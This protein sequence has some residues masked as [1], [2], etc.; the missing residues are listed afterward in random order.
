MAEPST[1]HR[2]EQFARVTGSPG[3][4]PRLTG[5][6]RVIWPFVGSALVAGYLLRAAFPHPPLNTTAIGAGFLALAGVLAWSVSLGRHRLH[7]YLKGAKGEEWVARLLGFLPASFRVYHG[8]HVAGTLLKGGSDYDHVVVGPTGVFLI[9][10]KNW[11]GRITVQ[12]GEVLYNGEKPDRPPLMQVKAAAA[13]LRRDLRAE[14]HRG[15]DVQP[16]LCFAEGLL[17]GGRAGAAGVLICTRHTLMDTLQEQPEHTLP[18]A[19]QDKVVYY[20]DQQVASRD[21]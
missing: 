14:A 13:A 19:I 8:M 12:D 6:L 4:A 16:V 1:N 3:E 20:L 10:T 9:E 18:P 11:A 5:L 17:Q 7:S 15:V 21:E 2:P